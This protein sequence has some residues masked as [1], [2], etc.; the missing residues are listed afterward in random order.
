MICVII[1][2]NFTGSHY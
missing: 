2:R 1:R